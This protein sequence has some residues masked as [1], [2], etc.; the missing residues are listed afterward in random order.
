MCV[1]VYVCMCMC[2]CMYVCACVS[3]QLSN[4]V[5]PLL[6]SHHCVAFNFYFARK[7]GC[8]T[9]KKKLV[10]GNLGYVSFYVR[11]SALGC[12]HT[13]VQSAASTST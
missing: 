7:R 11:C 13:M 6:F 2:V 9:L 1:C 4:C 12:H 5:V 3:Q 8:W 10:L